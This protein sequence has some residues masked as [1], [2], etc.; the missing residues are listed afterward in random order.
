MA[1]TSTLSCRTRRGAIPAARSQA[2]LPATPRSFPNRLT[3][4]KHPALPRLDGSATLPSHMPT[5]HEPRP[6]LRARNARATVGAG[7]RSQRDTRRSILTCTN[8]TQPS[9]TPHAPL[10][11]A[12]PSLPQ[13]GSSLGRPQGRPRA[14]HGS[15]RRPA[16][17]PVVVAPTSRRLHGPVTYTRL[18]AGA[19]PKR[20][21][22]TRR[23]P[24][25]SSTSDSP[26]P[27]SPARGRSG[28][29]AAR[30]SG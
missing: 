24:L 25:R 23:R 12:A 27:G 2:P 17:D 16:Y 30:V 20:T 21:R 19:P 3:C 10:A 15:A 13:K 11:P 22:P 4:P 18:V 6:S 1:G 14:T 9:P 29:A 8:N 7:E 26:S 5:R 28:R